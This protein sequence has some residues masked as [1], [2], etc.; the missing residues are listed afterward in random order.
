MCKFIKYVGKRD[1]I[2][3]VVEPVNFGSFFRD[4]LLFLSFFHVPCILLFEVIV[5]SKQVL[6]ETDEGKI[7]GSNTKQTS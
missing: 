5:A 3:E 7:R 4:P 1:F 2:L 6:V